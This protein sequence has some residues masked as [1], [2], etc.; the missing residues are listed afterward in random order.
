MGSLHHGVIDRDLRR[1]G[2]ELAVE[3]DEAEILVRQRNGLTCRRGDLRLE[4]RE[5]LQ[6]HVGAKHEIARVPQIAAVDE[7]PGAFLARLLDE[8]L[9]AAHLRID[10]QR[11]AGVNITV[12]GRWMVRRDA[13]SDDFSRRDRDRRLGGEFGEA[14]GDDALGDSRDRAWEFAMAACRR[15]AAPR[16]LQLRSA[17]GSAKR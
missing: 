17:P 12:A 4:T 15:E 16:S 8:A 11:F 5:L 14:L 2:K 9:D 13:K 1:P 10:R 3:N 7:F 6:H